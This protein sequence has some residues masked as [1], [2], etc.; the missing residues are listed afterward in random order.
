MIRRTKRNLYDSR[1]DLEL[2][3]VDLERRA[4]HKSRS[5]GVEEVQKRVQMDSHSRKD[6]WDNFYRSEGG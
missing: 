2:E 6:C 4:I 5:K 3:E 1:T